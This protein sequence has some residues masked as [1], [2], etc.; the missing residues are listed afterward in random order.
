MTEIDDFAPYPNE[1]DATADSLARHFAVIAKAEEHLL[2]NRPSGD[3]KTALGRWYDDAGRMCADY[4][5]VRLLRDFMRVAPAA[6]DKA[7]RSLVGDWE[8][9]EVLPMN[10]WDWLQGYGISPEAVERF[11][12]EQTRAKDAA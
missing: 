11:A 1:D 4:A 12:D 8:D 6:A 3:D 10:L 5:V 9:G 7:A 2:K